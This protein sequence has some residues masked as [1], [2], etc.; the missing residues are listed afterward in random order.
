MVQLPEDPGFYR[1][2]LVL[3]MERLYQ[4]EKQKPLSWANATRLIEMQAP[5]SKNASSA[6]EEG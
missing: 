5:E 4:N 2:D 3:T 6:K 1:Q